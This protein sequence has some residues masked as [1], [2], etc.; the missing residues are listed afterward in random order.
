MDWNECHRLASLSRGAVHLNI[1]KSK[2]ILAG[3]RVQRPETFMKNPQTKN[4]NSFLTF[5][6]ED[7]DF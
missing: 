4:M 3:M 7:L 5:L 1:C 2:I 6:Q